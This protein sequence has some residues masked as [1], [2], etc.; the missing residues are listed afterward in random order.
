VLPKVDDMGGRER[1]LVDHMVEVVMA[2]SCLLQSTS[3][4]RRKAEIV[5]EGKSDI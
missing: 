2:V 5:S 3:I 1:P 4:S